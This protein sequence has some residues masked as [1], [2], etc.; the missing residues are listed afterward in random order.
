MTSV[1]S[2]SPRVNPSLCIQ[3]VSA[4]A[5]R[6]AKGRGAQGLLGGIGV[7]GAAVGELSV[8]SRAIRPLIGALRSPGGPALRVL[9]GPGGPW[10]RG[11]RGRQAPRAA[12][13]ARTD[14]WGRYWRG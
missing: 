11:W 7:A 5:C 9:A 2:G 1:P 3:A 8:G 6:P 13:T 14:P 12:P 10:G 4:V